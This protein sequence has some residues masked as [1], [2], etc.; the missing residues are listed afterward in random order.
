MA[1]SSV[2]DFHSVTASSPDHESASASRSILSTD[3]SFERGT[4]VT[5]L[6]QDIEISLTE[7]ID[8]SIRETFEMMAGSVITVK[9]TCCPFKS[10]AKVLQ[11]ESAISVIMGWTGD[12]HG[13]LSLTLV[14]EAA[15]AWTRAL[16]E[17][18]SGQVDQTVIDAVGE[19]GNMV[20]GGTKRRMS[21]FSLTMSLPTVVRAGSASMEFPSSTAPL[22]MVYD[23][24][25]TDMT[26]LIA[27]VKR[28]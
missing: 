26:I 17:H 24:E 9:E 10:N 1:G 2:Y 23:Y 21:D 5:A 25:A 28:S 18:D 27:L 11:A 4:I 22:R 20:V 12:L 3:K 14:D 15:R 16:I 13:S 19:L 7:S 6:C 8:Q